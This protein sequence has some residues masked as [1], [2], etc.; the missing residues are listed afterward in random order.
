MPAEDKTFSDAPSRDALAA[1]LDFYRHVGVDI[2][3]GESPRDFFSESQVA[4]QRAASGRASA[5]QSTP[6]AR[7]APD[8]RRAEAGAAPDAPRQTPPFRELP[9]RRPLPPPMPEAARPLNPALAADAAAVA[10]S[11]AQSAAAARDLDELRAAL[12]AFEGCALKTTATQLVFE[13]GAREARVHL[14]GEAPGADEDREGRPFVGRAGQLLDKMLASIG[15]DRTQV[16]ISNVVPW[17]PPG[18]R[19]PSPLEVAACLPFTRRQ[20]ELVGA[21][22]VI[23]LGAP[24]MQALLEIKDGILKTRGRWMAFAGGTKT[25]PAMAMLHPAYL[26]RQPL[27]KRLAWRD[28]R[29]LRRALDGETPDIGSGA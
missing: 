4:K 13:D 20:I 19:T 7:A 28:L 17:R 26:L 9:P 3:L 6:Q 12:E 24:S 5:E 21:D 15:L 22:Y 25:V 2:A 16:Y 29:A 1:A 14:V 10:A 27:Q 8:L 23:C 18:N 11:A